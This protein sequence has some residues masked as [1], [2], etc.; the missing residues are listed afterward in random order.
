MTEL[1]AISQIK[2]DAATQP[3]TNMN[4]AVVEEYA[5]GMKNGGK[6]PPID[7]FQINGGY[8]LVDGYH[9]FLAAQSAGV[10]KILCEVHEGD[11]RAAILFACHVN[12]THGLR[13]TNDDKK[14]AIERLLKDSEWSQWSNN[15]I[16][17]ICYV[18]P[19]LVAKYRNSHYPKS[20][21]DNVQKTRTYA[22]KSGTVSHMKTE[23]IGKKPVAG[24]ENA[25]DGK[26][27]D[28]PRTV[29]ELE[30]GVRKEEIAE[31]A[32]NQPPVMQK[33]ASNEPLVDVVIPP[34]PDTLHPAS[35]DWTPETCKKVAAGSCKCPDGECHVVREQQR[36]PVCNLWNLPI[37]QISQENGCHIIQRRKR[38]L[39]ASPEFQ[40][41]S[42]V[43][44]LDL[45]KPI[46][47]AGIKIVKTPLTPEELKKCCD[48]LIERS[49]FFS[50]REV[51]LVHELIRAQYEGIKTS[52]DFWKKA[53][54]WFLTQAGE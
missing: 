29:S 9:R 14:R 33:G 16:A 49:G 12:S 25:H 23:N 38:E 53:G 50:P 3:R 42:A 13:R 18:S 28:P 24:F 37:N 51:P 17:E 10:K 40:R 35:Q 2:Q 52:A 48:D 45:A 21:S 31:A 43:A 54:N 26:P 32:K 46:K 20:D 19:E 39:M 7:V 22:T 41:A 36:G 47:P 11:M 4:M 5:E 15:K 6:F 8:I 34:A 44:R 1:I 27:V 30:K